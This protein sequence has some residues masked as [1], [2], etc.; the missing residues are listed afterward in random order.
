MDLAIFWPNDTHSWDLAVGIHWVERAYEAIP[1]TGPLQ[2]GPAT[3]FSK[4]L[5]TRYIAAGDQND[6][7]TAIQLVEKH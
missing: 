3:D 2:Y 1:L 4:L 6:L 7:D 5:L